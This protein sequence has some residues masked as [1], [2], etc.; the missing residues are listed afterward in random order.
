MTRKNLQTKDT[1]SV[2]QSLFEK[3]VI[4][5]WVKTKC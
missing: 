5:A 2:I 1:R 3:K 4:L